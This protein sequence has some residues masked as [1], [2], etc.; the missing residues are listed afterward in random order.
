MRGGLTLREGIYLME[1]LFHTGR[2]RGIDL[3]EVNPMIG[4]ERDVKN[5]VDAAI[6]IIKAGLGFDRRGMSTNKINDLP[7][8]TFKGNSD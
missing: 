8:Q 3:V 6:S 7:L 4:T 2:L 5:T 1:K